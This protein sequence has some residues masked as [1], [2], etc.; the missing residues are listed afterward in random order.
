MGRFMLARRGFSLIELLVVLTIVS[1]LAGL[2]LPAVQSAREAARRTQCANNLRQMSVALHHYHATW[3]HFPAGYQSPRGLLWSGSLLPFVEETALFRTLDKDRD[4]ENSPNQDAC[5]TYLSIFRC[6]SD[7]VPAHVFNRMENRVPC[8]YLAGNSGTVT[9]ESGPP[10]VAGTA[11]S[12]GLFAIDSRW[13]MR[14]IRDGSSNTVLVGEAVSIVKLIGPD[15]TGQSQYLDHWYI[16]TPE[17]T[18]NEVSESMGSTGVAINS[19]RQT[20]RWAD[21][22]ELAF[23]SRH[24]ANGAQIA[25]ADGHLQLIAESIDRQAW[26]DLGTRR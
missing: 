6:P 25:F 5:A 1:V 15:L 13:G 11:D 21:E 10:P 2:L 23:S 20:V 8:N 17:G 14:H 19:Y 16:G 9:R 18:G 7:S 26:S 3:H 12:N 4:W 24:A 22:K